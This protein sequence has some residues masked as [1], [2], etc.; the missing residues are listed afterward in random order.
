M[1][2]IDPV[3]VDLSEHVLA[4]PGASATTWLDPVRYFTLLTAA[5][6]ATTYQIPRSAEVDVHLLKGLVRHVEGPGG[7]FL[8]LPLGAL[9]RRPI[10]VHC[11]PEFDHVVF[12]VTEAW[13]P[14]D[15]GLFFV[16]RGTFPS[17]ADFVRSLRQD[18]SPRAQWLRAIRPFGTTVLSWE[19]TQ[20][21]RP[22]GSSLWVVHC[23]A[24]I[25]RAQ[26][27]HVRYI[28]RPPPIITLRA[29]HPWPR[30]QRLI[31]RGV[32][33]DAAQEHLLQGAAIW[34]AIPRPL[35]CELGRY[36]EIPSALD[37]L[38]CTAWQIRCVVPCIPGYLLWAIRDGDR[39]LGMCTA[40]I[41][42][43]LVASALHISMWELP[44]T[45]LHGEGAVWPYPRDLST[46]AHRCVSVSHDTAEA[47][48]CLGQDLPTVPQARSA[49]LT[50]GAWPL[51]LYLAPRYTWVGLLCALAPAW[52]VRL[53]SHIPSA[54]DAPCA[55]AMPFQDYRDTTRTCTMSWT[56][57]LSRQ[58]H[59][60]AVEPHVLGRYI[61]RLC[62]GQ[63]VLI[64]LWS[65]GRSSI[66][67]RERVRSAS[68][69][70]EEHLGRLGYVR[71]VHELCVAFDTT[72]HALDVIIL[73]PQTGGTWWILQDQ[74]GREILRPVMRYYVDA[75]RFRI[76]TVSPE[77]IGQ[78]V[79]PSYQVRQSMPLPQGARG[80]VTRDH[81]EFEGGF[82]Q[83]I[84]HIAA[85][86]VGL[87][88][89]SLP[90]VFLLSARV[91]VA[92][93]SAS[94]SSLVPAQPSH[95]TPPITMRIWAYN[96]RS[97]LDLPWKAE[98]CNTR[99]LHEYVC[100]VF[101][102]QG[103]GVFLP[104][105]GA[106]EEQVQ[107]LLF[108][109]RSVIA[110]PQ[111]RY[112]LLHIEDRAC[113]VPGQ[114][115]F[116]WD[117]V[118]QHIRDLYSGLRIP[119]TRPALG[120][121]SQLFL[122]DY[123]LPELA[124]G[125]VIQILLGALYMETSRDVWD[126]APWAVP[127]PFFQ[128]VPSRGPAGEGAHVYAPATASPE[129][130]SASSVSGRE[131]GCQTDVELRVATHLLTN[132]TVQNLA[133]QL[134]GLAECLQELPCNTSYLD[135]PSSP[136]A[137][138]FQGPP[139]ADSEDDVGT[140]GPTSLS[141]RRLRM[142]PQSR[143]LS[144]GLIRPRHSQAL[145]LVLSRTCIGVCVLAAV[146]LDSLLLAGRF[147]RTLCPYIRGGANPARCGTHCL[148][149]C[150]KISVLRIV[151]G[152]LPISLQPVVLDDEAPLFWCRSVVSLLP[153]SSCM[154][155]ARFGRPLCRAISHR[156]SSTILRVVRQPDPPRSLG[157]LGPMHKCGRSKPICSYVTETILGS[158]LTS[159][160]VIWV[161]LTG[162]C[163]LLRM[164]LSPKRVGRFPSSYNTRVSLGYGI[165]TLTGLSSS[166]FAK[167]PGGILLSVLS[168]TPR[169]RPSLAYSCP[170]YVCFP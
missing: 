13:D 141:L 169:V 48:S 71:D 41:T 113:V 133:L 45:F 61:E 122:P 124:T 118:A 130:I 14:L 92:A 90:F 36:P 159:A 46:V 4:K 60:F 75:A 11:A 23:S 163:L 126:P 85:A 56:L 25:A 150:S 81:P 157:S 96:V 165:G 87:R 40:S 70:L 49:T 16:F 140:S 116:D 73:V 149:P 28:S 107:H 5:S 12:R 144:L 24:D 62:P 101:H 143:P 110:G 38:W 168:E 155:E 64:Q 17:Y 39:L 7:T 102:T 95:Y 170:Q 137:P 131:V 76:L 132:H 93:P 164:T 72:N 128:F 42:W 94:S 112:W 27:H 51:C 68:R 142:F 106:P 103:R 167:T 21:L 34:Q 111:P 31:S 22:H 1:D 65:P 79:C 52:A 115:P 138:L 8:E 153:R 44:Q 97:P 161:T 156:R 98:G 139:G 89:W 74:V 162:Q 125:S 6:G 84:L 91:S 53:D 67:L 37:N 50:Y 3:E 54:D 15:D 59:G 18:P 57:E 135:L 147:L 99:W 158:R 10:W 152:G 136:P 86:A 114:H 108:V 145:C 82:R 146:F 151:A 47:V 55:A 148:G 66:L 2:D 119:P 20:L 109:P 9:L 129:R 32:Q 88:G 29:S 104:T 35:T 83:G 123:P 154:A 77:G 160:I 166:S 26:L 127:G 121:Q 43:D 63:E 58:T 19:Y 78:A 80:R 117:I 120:L 33:T 134:H 100:G 69:Y 105:T 30:A